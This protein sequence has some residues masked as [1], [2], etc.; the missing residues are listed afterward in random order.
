MKSMSNYAYP[1][2]ILQLWLMGIIVLLLSACGSAAEAPGSNTS[3]ADSAFNMKIARALYFDLKTPAGF[4][5]EDVQDA[6]SYSISH[7]KNT[8]LLPVVD[9]DE[10]SSYE[11]SSDDFA[12][13]LAW[14]DQAA[15]YQL[16]HKQLIDNTETWL[17]HQFTRFDPDSPQFIHLHRV[18]KSSMLDRN[19]VIRSDEDSSYKGR[20]TML[21][22]TA[23]K[24]KFIIEYL[25]T[26]TLSNNFSNAVVESYTI[27]TD[28][29]FVHIMEQARLD[30]SHSESCDQVKLFEM[31][32]TVAKD[33]GFIWK[34]KVLMREF[35]AKR[36]GDYLEIC[37]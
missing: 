24:V 16:S 13:A 2:H 25:W 17:Y 32:Y 21:D 19:G 36:I 5:Q 7:I 37:D 1:S 28:S 4:Y 8:S 15:E 18:F 20:I 35:S 10:S 27:E 23:E 33:S 22:M 29:A 30:L 31:R 26:F 3:S 6:A 14:S 34:E 9:R 11:L 12:E